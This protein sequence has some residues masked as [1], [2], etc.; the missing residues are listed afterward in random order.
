MKINHLYT[1]PRGR[2]FNDGFRIKERFEGKEEG[3][4]ALFPKQQ[5]WNSFSN[6]FRETLVALCRLLQHFSTRS[7]LHQDSLWR[8]LRS[9]ML[10]VSGIREVI[11]R[12]DR[13]YIRRLASKSLANKKL[14]R[15]SDRN[16]VNTFR[17]LQNISF[18]SARVLQFCKSARIL[19]FILFYCIF[20]GNESCCKDN[21]PA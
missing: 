21:L 18:D 1:R 11:Q 5:K 10:R 15:V 16:Y 4:N 2:R 13:I 7:D 17:A 6:V 20:N 19:L 14:K 3:T 9:N 8:T 12:D